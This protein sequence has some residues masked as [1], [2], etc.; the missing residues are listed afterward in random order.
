M[1][2]RNINAARSHDMFSLINEHRFRAGQTSLGLNI[3]PELPPTMRPAAPIFSPPFLFSDPRN[4]PLPGYGQSSLLSP[5]LF[6][7]GRPPFMPTNVVNPI[8]QR[9]YITSL[10]PLVIRGNDAITSPPAPTMLGG[11]GS[12]RMLPQTYAATAS[13]TNRNEMMMGAP[14]PN[15][16]RMSGRFEVPDPLDLDFLFDDNLFKFLMSDLTE[17]ENDHASQKSPSSTNNNSTGGGNPLSPLFVADATVQPQTD[18][19]P[20]P[21][22][23]PIIQNGNGNNNTGGDDTSLSNFSMFDSFLAEQYPVDGGLGDL[24]TNNE[25]ENAVNSN[26]SSAVNQNQTQYEDLPTFDHQVLETRTDEEF[27]ESLFDAMP[28]SDKDEN[29]EDDTSKN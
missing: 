1:L 29:G 7:F 14:R 19:P 25:N 12:G 21:P 2:S 4:Q 13:E 10:P 15:Q 20:L 9:N 23:H 27:I 28:F 22:S 5:H 18:M 11:G 26:F 3:T 17:N 6:N 24:I 8:Y 16:R